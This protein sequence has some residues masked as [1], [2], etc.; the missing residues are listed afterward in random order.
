MR[1][2]LQAQSA[3]VRGAVDPWL[4]IERFVSRSARMNDWLREQALAC[5]FPFVVSSGLESPQTVSSM[6]LEA[7]GLKHAATEHRA[8]GARPERLAPDRA[9]WADQSGSATTMTTQAVIFG[10]GRLLPWD[11]RS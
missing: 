10:G 4:L 5:G 6:C 1:S 9:R 7:I 2:R 8:S 11:G 3:F